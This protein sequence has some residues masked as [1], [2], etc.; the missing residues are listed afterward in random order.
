MVNF[1]DKS[2]FFQTE[3]IFNVLTPDFHKA[4]R[5]QKT[6]SDAKTTYSLSKTSNKWL[7]FENSPFRKNR[8]KPVILY[9]KDENMDAVYCSIRSSSNHV[10]RDKMNSEAEIKEISRNLR[11]NMD[12]HVC[13]DEKPK[14]FIGEKAI[15]KYQDLYKNLDKILAENKSYGIKNSLMT[16]MLSKLETNRLLPLKMGVIKLHGKQTEINLK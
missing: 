6:K 1:N 15:V 9:N 12:V 3:P 10:G 2:S 16:E 11:E 14:D 7:T 5:H 4:K 13:E 8:L